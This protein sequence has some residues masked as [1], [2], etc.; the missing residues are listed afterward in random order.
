MPACPLPTNQKNRIPPYSSGCGCDRGERSVAL[1]SE[2]DQY[3][4]YDQLPSLSSNLHTTT[5]TTS[6][7]T[8]D[9]GSSATTT[10]DLLSIGCN[11]SK[12]R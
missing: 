12:S 3:V 5:T 7:I 1:Q 9:D 10:T 6:T 2:L 8:Y 11:C 4:I